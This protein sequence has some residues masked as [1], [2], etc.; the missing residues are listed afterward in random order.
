MKPKSLNLDLV[1]KSA[2]PGVAGAGKIL[3]HWFK[4]YNKNN[5]FST[6]IFLLVNYLAIVCVFAA[7]MIG[8]IILIPQFRISGNISL[9][10]WYLLLGTSSQTVNH[11]RAFL[12]SAQFNTTITTSC[13]SLV[14]MKIYCIQWLFHS[15]YERRSSELTFT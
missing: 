14:I 4:N 13:F 6:I 10:Y 1:L 9:M 8:L 7:G 2:Q 5:T 12:H 3:N 11:I 15:G